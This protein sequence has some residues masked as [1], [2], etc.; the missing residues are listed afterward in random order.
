MATLEEEFIKLGIH[1]EY[2]HEGRIVL[3]DLFSIQLDFDIEV[4]T[5]MHG[6]EDTFHLLECEVLY[7]G[8]LMDI[9]LLV[10]EAQLNELFR[11]HPPT[12]YVAERSTVQ[13]LRYPQ[14]A[15]KKFNGKGLMAR[16]V[17]T[18]NMGEED[19]MDI[20]VLLEP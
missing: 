18:E 6:F 15:L 17:T 11:I 4:Y 19:E 12:I 9:G 8:L 13:V 14:A 16:M 1:L 10:T 3:V 5:A 7:C 20:F 2:K